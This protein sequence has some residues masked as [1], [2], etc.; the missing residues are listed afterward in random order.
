[1]KTLIVLGLLSSGSFMTAGA[2]EEGLST[3][4]VILSRKPAS[5]TFKLI[6]HRNGK[7]AEVPNNYEFRSGDKFA[8]QVRLNEGSGYLYVLNRTIT[9]QPDRIRATASRGIRLA[10]N[11]KPTEVSA[12]EEETML[13]NE[14]ASASEYRLVYPA[15]HR[16]VTREWITVPAGDLFEMDANPGLEQLLVIISPRQLTDFTNVLNSSAKASTK[17]ERMKAQQAVRGELAQMAANS[18]TVEP[19]LDSRSILI[20]NLPRQKNQDPGTSKPGVAAPI[21]ATRPYL[22]ELT[23][24]HL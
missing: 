24:V 15:S 16:K 10:S 22:I 18:E 14:S 8:V 12:E 7:A 3:R 6:L 2:A 13:R 20:D 9:G 4:G 1:M 17:P 5:S 23:L 19:P 11:G 21:Q